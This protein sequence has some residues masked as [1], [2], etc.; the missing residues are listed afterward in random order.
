[1]QLKLESITGNVALYLNFSSPACFDAPD[2]RAH[3]NLATRNDKS[4][5]K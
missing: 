4:I 1:M 3:F 2:R 5:T